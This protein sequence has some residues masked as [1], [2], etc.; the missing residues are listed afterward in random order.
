[1]LVK[2]HHCVGQEL[3]I[4]GLAEPPAKKCKCRERISLARATVLVDRG[5]AAW[6]VES[7]IYELGFIMCDL[8]R[9]DKT[10]KNCPNCQ[11]TGKVERVLPW[12][13][14]N[15]EVVRISRRPIDPNERK[16]SSGLAIKTPRVATIEEEHIYRTYVEGKRSAQLRI[17]EY[18]DLEYKRMLADVVL[19]PA[20]EYDK[21]E[22]ENWGR[23]LE[24]FGANRRAQKVYTK[25]VKSR[26]KADFGG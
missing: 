23:P 19:V 6:V 8:C 24:T 9:G 5:E 15:N 22:R 12:P 10:F 21:G 3:V 26:A 16:Q 14:F 25:I 18:G 11:N 7:R 13:K 4:Q 20:K 1:V 17:E 2:I